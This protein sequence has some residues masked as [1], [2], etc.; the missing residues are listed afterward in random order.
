M[1]IARK[2]QAIKGD[3]FAGDVVSTFGGIVVIH[4]VRS[5]VFVPL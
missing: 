5:S 2:A 3:R 4:S 1:A